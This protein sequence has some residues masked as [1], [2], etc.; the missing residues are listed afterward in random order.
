MATQN[1]E[2]YPN[3][4][5]RQN[6]LSTKLPKTSQKIPGF[7]NFLSGKASYNVAWDICCASDISCALLQDEQ[8]EEL[9]L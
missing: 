9:H 3:Y 4:T 8:E 5:E 2:S 6:E 7:F 1:I